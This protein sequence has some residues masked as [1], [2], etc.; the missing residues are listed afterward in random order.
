[1]MVDLSKGPRANNLLSTINKFI[2]NEK[3]LAQKAP[4]HIHC[5][6]EIAGV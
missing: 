2:F 4:F 1:M 6:K 5:A 3:F